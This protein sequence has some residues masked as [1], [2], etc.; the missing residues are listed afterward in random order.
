[1]LNPSPYL[2][3]G[4]SEYP[5]LAY[6]HIQNIHENLIITPGDEVSAI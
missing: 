3:R 5:E 6:E 4:F 2:S 1:M